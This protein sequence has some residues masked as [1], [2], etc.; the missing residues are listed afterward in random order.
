MHRFQRRV[1]DNEY[2][3]NMSVS[4]Q[5]KKARGFA[6]RGFAMLE[7]LIALVV[8]LFGVLGIAGMQM[9]AINN[10][11]NASYQS[12]AVMLA[13]SMVTKME[14]NYAYWSGAAGKSITIN[15]GTINGGPTA[16]AGS[17]GSATTAPPGGGCAT[18]D[19]AYFDLVNFG[20]A[21]AGG[22]PAGTAQITCSTTAVPTACTMTLTW[23]ENNVALT[24]KAGGET[25]S[26]ATGTV[27]SNY[28]Y[29][30]VVNIIQ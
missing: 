4:M 20:T 30:T 11:Q 10:T 23:S 19:M 3:G 13:S 29:Q 22:L 17:C 14:A 8:I 7:A 1:L 5:S 24:N 15:G 12:L 25:G 28:Q 9:Y 6:M 27:N 21:V 16:Y 26:L 18:S 2:G